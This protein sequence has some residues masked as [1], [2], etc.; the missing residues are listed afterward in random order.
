[1]ASTESSAHQSTHAALL[2]HPGVHGA[3]ELD[4]HQEVTAF[5]L[6][7]VEGAHPVVSL[8]HLV[9]VL[10]LLLEHTVIIADA[11]AVTGHAASGHGLQVAGGQSAEAAVAQACV[12]LH[13]GQIFQVQTE[14]G[15]GPVR[16]VVEPQADEVVDERLAR[17]VLQREVVHPLG[18]LVVVAA[19]GAQPLLHK[20]VAHSQGQS[21]IIGEGLSAR[22]VAAQGGDDMPEGVGFQGLLIVFLRGAEAPLEII[23][24]Y[25]FLVDFRH[26]I[27]GLGHTVVLRSWATLPGK[28]AY[29]GKARF[30]FMRRLPH[31]HRRNQGILANSSGNFHQNVT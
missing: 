4:L 13:L 18:L 16:C 28:L 21:V 14:V 9:A 23:R 30:P 11:V 22:V 29:S 12:P 20:P 3:A 15:H 10:D 25:R 19:L 2:V 6:P 24:V 17:Q 31:L 7:G 5:E 27:L 8:L 1:M 26:A